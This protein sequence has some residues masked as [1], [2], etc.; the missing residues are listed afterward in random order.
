MRD[1]VVTASPVN[2]GTPDSLRGWTFNR[3]IYATA[4]LFA[5]VL[6]VRRTLYAAGPITLLH[7]P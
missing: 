7:R 6:L 2:G 5:L 4:G 1:G 3:T